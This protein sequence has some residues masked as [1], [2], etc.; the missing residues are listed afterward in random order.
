MP[1]FASGDLDLWFWP[2]NSSERGTKHV[3]RVNSAQLRKPQTDGAKNRTFRSSLRAV[4]T[5]ILSL[6]IADYEVLANNRRNYEV[7][8][9]SLFGRANEDTLS[10]MNI[11]PDTDLTCDRHAGRVTLLEPTYILICFFRLRRS[12]AVGR[13]LMSLNNLLHTTTITRRAACSQN[14]RF[15]SW[16]TRVNTQSIL[17]NFGQRNYR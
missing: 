10:F 11:L 2:S 17:R 1:F 6:C 5:R 15:I 16:V 7:M 13:S 14:V 4:K 12:F 3:F 9:W 8:S